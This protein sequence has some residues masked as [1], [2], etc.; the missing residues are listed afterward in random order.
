[1]YVCVC[2]KFG[3]KPLHNFSHIFGKFEVFDMKLQLECDS[4][5]CHATAHLYNLLANFNRL[6]T[7]CCT[8]CTIVKEMFY[9][10]ALS[11]YDKIYSPSTVDAY[12]LT[13]P[14]VCLHVFMCVCTSRLRMTNGNTVL[15]V[16]SEWLLCT[17]EIYGFRSDAMH[18]HS[19]WP[20]RVGEDFYSCCHACD[21]ALSPLP[22]GLCQLP[23]K[24]IANKSLVLHFL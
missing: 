7:H 10:E 14:L 2:H 16:A 1:M 19:R 12:P 4:S 11:K 21:C 5:C 3:H 15:H 22:A 23:G 20:P 13:H 24:W 17:I 9:V 8:C 6:S 18:E